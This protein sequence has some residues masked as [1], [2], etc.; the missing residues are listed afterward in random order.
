M[1]PPIPKATQTYMHTQ[2][3]AENNSYSFTWLD[4]IYKN[5][6]GDTREMAAW[7]IL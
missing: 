3:M 4:Y 5:L 2:T 6:L 1:N 7:K